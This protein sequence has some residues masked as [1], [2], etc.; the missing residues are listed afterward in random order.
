MP[1]VIISVLLIL[2]VGGVVYKMISDK[3]KGKSSCSCGCE[4]CAAKDLC[5]TDDHKH[6]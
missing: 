6:E 5:H 4:S 2:A 3:K 1:T